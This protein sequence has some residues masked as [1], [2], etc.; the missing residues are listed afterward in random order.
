MFLF[1]TSVSEIT[2]TFKLKS[3][4]III[5]LYQEKKC[6]KT[7]Q[8]LPTRFS[9]LCCVNSALCLRGDVV[10]CKLFCYFFLLIKLVWG[11]G[12]SEGERGKE[13]T[14]WFSLQF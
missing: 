4:F 7:V 13:K 14:R 12:L 10:E 8:K 5:A 9:S 11:G 1:Y 6:G 2:P 3:K